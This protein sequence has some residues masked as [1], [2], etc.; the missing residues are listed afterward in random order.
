MKLVTRV[1]QVVKVVK[2][3]RLQPEE[4]ENLIDVSVDRRVLLVGYLK[5]RMRAGGTCFMIW[6]FLDCAD[7]LYRLVP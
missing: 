5:N 3:F 7:I 1:V 2:D 6:A 4:R